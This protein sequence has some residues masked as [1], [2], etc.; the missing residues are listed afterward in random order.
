M[1]GRHDAR[2]P[3]FQNARRVAEDRY[4]IGYCGLSDVDAGVR[5]LPLGESDDG[6]F[7]APTYENV[8]SAAYPLSRLL[9]FA[10][11]KPPGEP[12]DPVLAELLRFI[13]SRQGQQVVLEHAVYLPLRSEQAA[14]AR[15]DMN[16]ATP[17]SRFFLSV[18]YNLGSA[19]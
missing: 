7:Y 4:G 13:L 14:D 19:R 18:P 10:T 16:G 11:N 5:I 15:A 17:S 2:R 1:A 9:Y 8:A 12:L 3:G 6:P